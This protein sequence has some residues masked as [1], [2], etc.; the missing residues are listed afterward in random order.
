MKKIKNKKTSLNM[1]HGNNQIEG[2]TYREIINICIDT[3]RTKT[4]M[5]ED[6]PV[7]VN[8]MR[9]RIKLMD[10]IDKSNGE[11]KLEDDIYEQVKVFVMLRGENGWVVNDKELV[12]F[13]DD[14]LNAK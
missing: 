2:A 4:A 14:Y 8:D 10:I 3:A 11:I 12:Q 5:G 1:I 13:E 7:S 9:Q 6:T